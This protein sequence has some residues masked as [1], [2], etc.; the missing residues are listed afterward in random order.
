[1]LIRKPEMIDQSMCSTISSTIIALVVGRS[2]GKEP[3][4]GLVR[5]VIW[6]LLA[7]VNWA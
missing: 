7:A 1:M 6:R 4:L 2:N 3:F 5:Q